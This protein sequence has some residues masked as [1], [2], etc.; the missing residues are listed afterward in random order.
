MVSFLGGRFFSALNVNQDRVLTREELLNGFAKWIAAWDVEK[1]GQLSE[2]QL[3][4]GLNQA[5]PLTRDAP[6]SR[7]DAGPSPRTP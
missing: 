5:L 7:T 1:R 6:A 3:R 4:T 2:E